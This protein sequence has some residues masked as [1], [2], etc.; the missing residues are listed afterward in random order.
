MS[1]T[2]PGVRPQPDVP[3][4]RRAPSNDVLISGFALG[5][6]AGLAWLWLFMSGSG[7]MAGDHMAMMAIEP[8]SGAYLWPAFIMWALMMVAMMLPSA[9]PMILLHARLDKSPS[10]GKRLLNNLLF[11]LTYLIVWTAFSGAMAALQ[12]LLVDSGM[13]SAITLEL[14]NRRI[15]GVLLLAA[16]A[17][18]LSGL[19]AACLDQCRSPI[20]FI[21]RF[22]RPGAAGA[23]RL[24]LI[25]GLYCLG[26]CWALMLLLFA[27]GV[28]NLAWVAVLA[29]AV[30]VEKWAP[31][32]WR[33]S[34]IVASLLAL[35]GIALLVSG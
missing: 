30:S 7:E 19:K 12:A 8:W 34:L 15:A 10:A 32:G 3:A 11:A 29:I 18:Q 4:R 2:N 9:A 24:G 17:Y 28:M 27:G 25:H 16:A 5:L 13:L 6:A 33:V 31:P 21:M 14:G 22:W 1:S 20:H 26:C 23:V 35:A